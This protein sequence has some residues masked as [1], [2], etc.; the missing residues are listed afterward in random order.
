MPISW[1]CGQCAHANDDEHNFCKHCGSNRM[2]NLSLPA[3]GPPVQQQISFSCSSC[4]NVTGRD[5][6]KHCGYNAQSTQQEYSEKTQNSISAVPGTFAQPMLWRCVCSHK[7]ESRRPFCE[8]CGAK[9]IDKGQPRE[10]SAPLQKGS[11]PQSALSRNILSEIKETKGKAQKPE[12][13]NSSGKGT[14]SR[15]PS[16]KNTHVMHKQTKQKKHRSYDNSRHPTSSSEC[17]SNMRNLQYDVI[18]PPSNVHSS[19]LNL[20]VLADIASGSA[21]LKS[22]NPTKKPTAK[23]SILSQ[24]KK[25]KGLKSVEK[26]KLSEAPRKERPMSI[27]DQIMSGPQLK[28]VE[29][30]H[31]SPSSSIRDGKCSNMYPFYLFDTLANL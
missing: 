22:P 20:R 31:Q 16:Q 4:G 26:R 7:N 21:S 15:L 30:M 2:T 3:A 29:K 6:C 9:A 18:S 27:L 19:A 8:K 23:V 5:G 13:Q 25:G 12:Y 1:N 10:S 14:F 24:I 11:I 17:E 28:K